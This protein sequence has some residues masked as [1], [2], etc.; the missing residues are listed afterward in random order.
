MLRGVTK[1]TVIILL[2]E[3]TMNIS[4][5]GKKVNRIKFEIYS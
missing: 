3:V 4:V 1:I 5:E 2:R